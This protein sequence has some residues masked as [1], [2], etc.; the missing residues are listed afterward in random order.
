MATRNPIRVFLCYRAIVTAGAT[1]THGLFVKQQLGCLHTRLPVEPLLYGAVIQEIG[2]REQHH[3]LMVSHPASHHLIA[4]MPGAAARIAV[5]DRL[6][7]P[8]RPEP[9][10]GAHSAKVPQTPYGVDIQGEAGG[11]GGNN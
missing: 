1:L 5:I 7:K 4:A 11:V 8:V 10:L 3:A 2:E 9:P 6:V